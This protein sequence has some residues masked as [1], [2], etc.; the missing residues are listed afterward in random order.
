V[1]NVRTCGLDPDDPRLVESRIRF[2]S[3]A[4]LANKTV[5]IGRLHL[6]QAG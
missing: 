4:T 1:P 3:D 2:G 5:T 6:E